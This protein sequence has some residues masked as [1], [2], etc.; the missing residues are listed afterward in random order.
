MTIFIAYA[1]IALVLTLSLFLIFSTKTLAGL[2]FGIKCSGI[3]NCV[4][5]EMLR[6]TFEAR[7]LR[8]KLPKP[9]K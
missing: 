3:V 2:N 1:V 5:L 6:A 8:M 4:F 9:L 7:L